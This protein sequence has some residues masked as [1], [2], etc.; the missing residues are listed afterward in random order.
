MGVKVK[1][2]RSL[3]PAWPEVHGKRLK[4][5][6]VVEVDAELAERLITRAAGPLAEAVSVAKRAADPR[7]SDFDAEAGKPGNQAKQNK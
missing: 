4:E 7:E 1:I 5:G 3:G 2:L 6:D